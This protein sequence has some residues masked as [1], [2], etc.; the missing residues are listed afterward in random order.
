MIEEELPLKKNR[1]EITE[2]LV[3]VPSL[4]EF[5]MEQARNCLRDEE[6]SIAEWIIGNL[7]KRGFFAMGPVSEYPKEKIEQILKIVQSFDPPGIAAA[8]LRE[9][10]LLQ[11]IRK[12]KET[13][14]SFRIV[15]D[16]FDDL[17]QHRISHIAKKIKSPPKQV[18]ELIQ[19]DLSSLNLQPSSGFA[20]EVSTTII[21]DIILENH[22]GKWFIE[23]NKRQLPA[24]EISLNF[25]KHLDSPILTSS[26]KT[27]MRGSL[28]SGKWLIRI[29]GR[30]RQI[31]SQITTALLAKQ[32]SFFNGEHTQFTPCTVEEIAQLLG[33]HK[34][35]IARA[36]YEKY[37][38]CP[39]GLFPLKSFI[40]S[41]T[42][43]QRAKDLLLQLIKTE[44]REK[45]LSDLEL[46]LKLKAQNIPCSRRTISKYRQ[47][48]KIPSSVYRKL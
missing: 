18:K 13:Q 42:N 1:L 44:N 40:T 39:Q 19:K 16:F 2:N 26:E 4:F 9:S 45:P 17:L 10:L 21:P 38:F 8:D 14:L 20:E 5:L 28:A 34:S 41:S 31:L 12:G 37:L 46:A 23:I 27:G 25:L 48:L 15:H 36:I 33:M 6:L 29:L 7:D 35:T 11:L 3:K 22:G 24:L 30:R 43:Q 32:V 47:S